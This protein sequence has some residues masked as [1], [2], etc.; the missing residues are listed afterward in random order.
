MVRKAIHVVVESIYEF[1]DTLDCGELFSLESFKS[2][3]AV[4][5]TERSDAKAMIYDTADISD[6]QSF[7]AKRF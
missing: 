3:A 7:P 5:F 1:A 6:E 2:N 4:K